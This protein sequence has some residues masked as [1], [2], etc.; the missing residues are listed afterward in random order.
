M[1]LSS[2]SITAIKLFIDLGEHYN[3]GYSTLIDISARKDISRK[4]LE[5]IIPLSR[6]TGLL[7]VVRGNQGGY[8]LS[9]SP[10]EISLK[11]IIYVTESSLSKYETSDL[12]IDNVLDKMDNLISDFLESITLEKLIENEIESY[13]NNYYI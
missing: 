9:K 6:N 11:D 3:E 1:K 5:Q 13:S 2:K 12:A 8:K 4:F 10:N 7:L